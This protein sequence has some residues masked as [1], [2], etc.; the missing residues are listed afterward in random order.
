[1][2]VNLP[3]VERDGIFPQFFREDLGWE[4]INSELDNRN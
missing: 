3:G 2:G 4:E 1:M